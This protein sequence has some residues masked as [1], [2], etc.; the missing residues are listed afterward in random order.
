M[1]AGG[2]ILPPATYFQKIQVVLD[3]YDI[4]LVADEV[5]CG[6]GRTGNMWGCNTYDIRP[7]MVTCAKQLSSGYLPISAVMISEKI[8]DVFKEQSR[9]HGAFG[10]GYT[11]GGH[12]VSC[13]VALETLKIY[14]ERDMIGHVQ[15]VAPHFLER[16]SELSDSSI[17]GEARGVGLIAALDL[18]SD[19]SSR[20]Q[21][22]P[23]A[24]AA[25]AIAASALARGLVVRALPGDVIGICPPLI[26]ENTQVDELFD[27]LA[28][29]VTETEALLRKAA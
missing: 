23:D 28:A 5:I 17:V 4:L 16:L 21:F 12:P 27:K 3:K 29:A 9:K 24:K 11:Y 13:A 14:E 25:P 6:F 22:S 10:M 20:A 19:K 18:V 1:G 26:I 8:Y 15:S 7:D 2:V